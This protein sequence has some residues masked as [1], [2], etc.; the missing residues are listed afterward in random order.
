M[1]WRPHSREYRGRRRHFICWTIRGI[2][3]GVQAAWPEPDHQSDRLARRFDLANIATSSFVLGCSMGDFFA[4]GIQIVGSSGVQVNNTVIFD[5]LGPAVQI[6]RGHG[7]TVVNNLAWTKSRDHYGAQ[8]GLFERTRIVHN[9]GNALRGDNTAAGSWVM[10]GFVTEGEACVLL[11]RQR[12]RV[13]AARSGRP[14]FMGNLAYGNPIGFQV[15]SLTTTASS[16]TLVRNVMAVLN[17]QCGLFVYLGGTIVVRNA[18]LAENAVG[19]SVNS[20]APSL[21]IT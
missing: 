21:I 2:A 12:D 16:C 15:T 13:V 14:N 7:N 10:A 8:S 1:C 6:M 17:H 19:L 20:Y 3:S 18:Y 5:T 9:S 11:G 4:P